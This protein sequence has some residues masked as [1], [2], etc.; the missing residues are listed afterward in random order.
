M[1]RA[2]RRSPTRARKPDAGHRSPETVAV[3]PR[4]DADRDPA[5]GDTTGPLALLDRSAGLEGRPRRHPEDALGERRPVRTVKRVAGPR[6]RQPPRPEQHP[7]RA[8][9]PPAPRRPPPPA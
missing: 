3:L 9:M 5:R 7:V 4:G 2:S 1:S 6:V 8:L